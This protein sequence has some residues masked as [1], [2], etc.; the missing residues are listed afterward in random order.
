MDKVL[1]DVFAVI[2]KMGTTKKSEFPDAFAKPRQATG[3]G[4][5]ND[6]DDPVKMVMRLRDLRKCAHDWQTYSSAGE[7]GRTV[8]PSEATIRD[9]RQIPFEV[10]P[11]EHRAY[12]QLVE[13]W[14]RRPMQPEYQSRL[15]EIVDEVV[16]SMLDG[17][18]FDVVSEFALYIQSRALTV[19]LNSDYGESEVW[20]GWGT[21]VFRSEGEALDG[22]KAA[23]LYDYIDKEI[24][25]AKKTP[26][27]DL[28]SVLLESEIEGRKLTKEEI[29]GVMILT[30][31]GGRDTVINTITNSIAYFAEHFDRLEM[32]RDNDILTTRAIEELIR[33]FSPLTQLA[34]VATEDTEVCGAAVPKDTRIS[35]CYAAANRD[36]TVFENPNEVQFDRK[37]NPHVAFGFSTHNCLGSAHARAIMKAVIA[38]LLEK[39]GRIQLGDAQENIEELGEYRRKVGFN[40]LNAKF[41]PK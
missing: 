16:E 31:A 27:G 20:I 6:Q 9:T 15:K 14:F 38:S 34:R 19:L 23:L 40:R 37:V 24:E 30:F 21:H 32:L 18:E 2:C 41:D 10:D 5:M 39:V 3:L 13:G 1:C 25:R 17:H 26:N 8:V 29:K 12:R 22:D 36:E 4:Y 7:V 11:P 35:L 28:Y 33:Y